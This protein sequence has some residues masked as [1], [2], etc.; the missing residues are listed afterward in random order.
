VKRLKQE[1]VAVG[2]VAVTGLG[3]GD[4]ADGH[5]LLLQALHS[6]SDARRSGVD[7]KSVV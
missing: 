7:R 3:S 6:R 1:P 4:L 5:G 2:E